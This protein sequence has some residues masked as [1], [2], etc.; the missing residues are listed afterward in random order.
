M[1]AYTLHHQCGVA[2]LGA[3][4]APNTI[5]AKNT[6]ASCDPFYYHG[7]TMIPAWVSNYMPSK[8]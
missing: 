6:E 3:D 8:V 5:A 4:L 2:V 7:L 1:T